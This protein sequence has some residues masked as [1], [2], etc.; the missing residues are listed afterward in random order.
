MLLRAR[1]PAAWARAAASLA[2]GALAGFLWAALVAG[3]TLSRDLPSE[4]EGQDLVV[5]G[6]IDSLPYRFDRSLRFNLAVEAA[7]TPDD[8]PVRLPPRLALSWYAE[9]RGPQPP[10][11]RP[12]ERWQLALRLKRPHGNA[13]P[14]GFDYEAWLLEQGLRATGSVRGDAAPGGANRRLATFVPGFA[15]VVERCRGWLRGRIERALSGQPYAGVIIALVIGDQRD[16]GQADWKI[17]T[18]TG[19]G[20]LVSIS[21]LHITMVAG[22]AALHWRSSCGGVHS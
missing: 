9:P 8:A 10:A 4:L 5:T 12:G 15:A 7:A 13:N 16:I 17:F 3:W 20:H 1:M 21:G 6:V 14:D 18:R 11:L 2:G 19:I 22:L